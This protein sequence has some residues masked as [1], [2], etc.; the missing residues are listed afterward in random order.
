[1]SLPVTASDAKTIA[2]L[3]KLKI[4]LTGVI[5]HGDGFYAFANMPWVKAC[6]CEPTHHHRHAHATA[7]T[8]MRARVCVCTDMCVCT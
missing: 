5:V 4:K 8:H 2:A 3:K 1:M 6:L 7:H